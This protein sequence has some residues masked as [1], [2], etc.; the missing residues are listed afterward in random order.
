MTVVPGRR[1]ATEA[2]L[3]FSETALNLMPEQTNSSPTARSS[4][5]KDST[6][7]DPTNL[8]PA[9]LLAVG[10][11]GPESVLNLDVPNALV[12]TEDSPSEKLMLHRLLHPKN[13]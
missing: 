3:G 13:A 8:H 5:F 12:P 6:L 10:E 9:R 11:T 7:F 4:V 2:W 1:P